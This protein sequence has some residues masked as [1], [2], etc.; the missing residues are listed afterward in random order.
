MLCVVVWL[1]HR[2]C[3]VGRILAVYSFRFSG[4]FRNW[5]MF[6]LL[7]MFVS[8]RTC[9]SLRMCIPPRVFM[10][11]LMCKILRILFRVRKNSLADGVSWDE[12]VDPVEGSDVEFVGGE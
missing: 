1:V 4:I 2:G 6:R 12:D 8:Q 11:L 10:V 5:M 3:T 9:K 7:K